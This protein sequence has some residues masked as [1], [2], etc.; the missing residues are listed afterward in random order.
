MHSLRKKRGFT[1]IELL[2]VISI[3]GILS[4]IVLAALNTARTKGRDAK[5]VSE[6]KSM[7]NALA[8]YYSDHNEYAPQ[9]PVAVFMGGLGYY[10]NVRGV[11]TEPILKNAL[12][13]HMKELPN[14]GNFLN[15]DKG[16][17]NSSRI[18]YRL[19][20]HNTIPGCSDTAKNCYA[21]VTWPETTN[22][23]GNANEATYFLSTGEVIHGYDNTLW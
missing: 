21:I 11:G 20:T 17:V 2:V 19:L 5:L 10:T 3:I 9:T 14:P 6:I 15:A 1:L 18:M 4:S 22:S 13:P 16:G 23:W 7:Q 12:A 8:L